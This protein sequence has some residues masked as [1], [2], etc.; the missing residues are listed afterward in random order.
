M[1]ELD[2]KCLP[3]DL[4]E[5]IEVDLKDLSVGQSV[6][7][8]RRPQAAEGPASKCITARRPGGRDASRVPRGTTAEG[9][10]RRRPPAASLPPQRSKSEKP[11]VAAG[12]RSFFESRAPPRSSAWA[13]PA[14]NTP[15]PGTTP[16]F[17]FVSGWRRKLGVTLNRESRFHGLVGSSRADGGLAADAADLHEPFRPGGRALARFYRIEPAEMLVVHDELDIPPGELR[18]KFGG[19]LGGHNGLKDIS[20]PSRQQGLLAPAHRHRPPGRPQRS[21]RLRAEPS[22]RRGAR[23]IDAA[24]DR[25]LD[26]WPLVAAATG[27]CAKPPCSMKPGA[28][29]RPNKEPRNHEPQMR[30][31]RPAQRR[32]VHPVQ[33]PD[34]G[35]HRGG[36]LSLL[37]HRAERRHR[38]SARSA[39]GRSCPPS[40]SRRRCSRPSSSSSTSPAWW[41]AP[42][43]AKAWA[44]SSWPTSAK[45]T[46]SSTWCAASTT[47]TWCT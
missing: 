24:I 38:R 28:G 6:H 46:P 2:I 19:G 23:D 4:P 39:P 25:A 5:F 45:P 47:R 40:S 33:R 29:N 17:G 11:D 43:R 22:A 31:R 42:A 12:T 1:N 15:K 35:R 21:G 18:L 20:R 34:Q 3:A 10:G 14:P 30:H 44:T 8:F 9:R 27:P 36:E 13:I 41:P 32:Q 37:H 16:G 26:A 7:V